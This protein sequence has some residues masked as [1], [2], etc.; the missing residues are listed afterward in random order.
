LGG[1]ALLGSILG[2]AIALYLHASTLQYMFGAFMVLVIVR[3]TIA[4]RARMRRAC[5]EKAAVP[6]AGE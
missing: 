2:V 3:E 1:G 6:G 4:F 5:M